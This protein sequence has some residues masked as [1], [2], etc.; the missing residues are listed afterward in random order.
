MCDP[1]PC[2]PLPQHA[3]AGPEPLLLV[4]PLPRRPSSWD[5]S[6]EAQQR[7][8]QLTEELLG[9]L[10]SAAP[11]APA[12]AAEH[13]PPRPDQP[14]PGRRPVVRRSR[15]GGGTGAAG[16]APLQKWQYGLRL[17]GHCCAAGLLDAAKLAEWAAGS[18]LL[19]ALP[20]AARRQAL[21]LLQL[22]L[23]AA[24]LAQQQALS[25]LDLCLRGAEGAGAAAAARRGPASEG[26]AEVQQ[27]LLQAAATLVELHPAAFVAA[28]EQLLQPLSALAG[29]GSHGSGSVRLC[30]E[31]IGGAR[32]RLSQAL[33]AR[34]VPAAQGLAWP[35]CRTCEQP[36]CSPARA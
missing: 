10:D 5:G 23:P 30:T 7:S 31:C 28:D 20:P 22:C 34:W 15:E 6:G 14:R 17:A 18:R 21:S 12:P 16:A 32:Q 33:H 29:G 36:A 4:P 11:A 13:R 35:A 1:A 3:T 25:L 8:R 9:F 24:Q 19:L 26:P 27:G 2:T